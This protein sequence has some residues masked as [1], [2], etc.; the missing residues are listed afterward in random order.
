MDLIPLHDVVYSLISQ[1]IILLSYL[2]YFFHIVG[3]NV[4]Q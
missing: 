3:Y 2:F 4:M 1:S